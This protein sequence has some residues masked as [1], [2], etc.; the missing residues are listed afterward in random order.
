MPAAPFLQEY[1]H[2]TF[3]L[4]GEG[5]NGKG[6]LFSAFIKGDSTSRLSTT[7]DVGKLVGSSRVSSTL[8]EQEPANLIGRMWAFDQDAEGLTAQQ[9]AQLKKLST[10]DA[11]TARKLGQN[12]VRFEPRAV[13]CVATN[14]DFVTEMSVAM[15]RRFAFVRM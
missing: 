3:V 8:A 12:M 6:T 14:L 15:R 7:I 13:L 11:L 4:A 9:T 2:L 1:K 10:G 5:S